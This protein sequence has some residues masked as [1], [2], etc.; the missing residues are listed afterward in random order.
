MKTEDEVSIGNL[1]WSPT[2][3]IVLGNGWWNGFRWASCYKRQNTKAKQSETQSLRMLERERRIVVERKGWRRGEKDRKKKMEREVLSL[4]IERLIQ[5]A[6]F[7]PLMVFEDHLYGD[8]VN[9]K[10]NW[11]P[12]L[13]NVFQWFTCFP[14]LFHSIMYTHFLPLFHPFS[15]LIQYPHDNPTDQHMHNEQQMHKVE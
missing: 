13:I 6:G 15:Q 12:T 10:R 7:Q 8:W 4:G 3:K 14:Y 11:P 5:A 2:W 9:V 1:K